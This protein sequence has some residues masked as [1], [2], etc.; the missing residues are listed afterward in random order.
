MF[1]NQSW[2]HEAAGRQQFA[3]NIWDKHA[4]HEIR[5]FLFCFFFWISQ[6]LPT[7]LPQCC[8]LSSAGWLPSS[9]VNTNTSSLVYLVRICLLRFTGEAEHEGLCESVCDL[10]CVCVRVCACLAS[11]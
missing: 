2:C 9:K 4:V 10:V 1:M 3:P 6:L 8:Y 11:S 5:Q 7:E